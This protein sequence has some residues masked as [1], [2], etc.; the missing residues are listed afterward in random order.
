MCTPRRV[1]FPACMIVAIVLVS[2]LFVSEGRFA[3]PLDEGLLS[4]VRGLDDYSVSVDMELACAYSTF[5]EGT[6]AD[7]DGVSDGT[8]CFDCGTENGRLAQVD[9]EGV[10]PEYI[11][12]AGG[13]YL[14]SNLSQFVGTCQDDE[15]VGDFTDDDCAGQIQVYAYEDEGG[16]GPTGGGGPM[17]GK[18]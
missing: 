11:E 8:D 6:V 15:C 4:R 13:Q 9:Q 10:E 1:L 16:G 17:L 18:P 5:G 14:C 7:C 3:R 12:A 2:A